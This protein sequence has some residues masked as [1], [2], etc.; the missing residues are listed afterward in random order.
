ME[1]WNKKFYLVREL[2]SLLYRLDGCVC[3]G[4]CHIVTDDDNIDDDSLDYII[5]YCD[6]EENKGRI[7]KEV[8][9][10][11]CVILKDMT[12][13]QRSILFWLI[14]HGNCVELSEENEVLDIL[15]YHNIEDIVNEY[16]Y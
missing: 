13:T 6:R 7:D 3:G 9:K 14:R 2:I 5:E 15:K 10:M 8:S 11:I 4:L 16:K 12:F 1:L